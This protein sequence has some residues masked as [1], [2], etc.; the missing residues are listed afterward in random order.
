MNGRDFPACIPDRYNPIKRME[1]FTGAYRITNEA[2]PDING[3]QLCQDI[4]QYIK[5][6]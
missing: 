6:V 1:L 3:D 5:E 4:L 2:E